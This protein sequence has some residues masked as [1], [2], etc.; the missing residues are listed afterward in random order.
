[1]DSSQRSAVTL[2]QSLCVTTSQT[3]E[4]RSR[5]LHGHLSCRCINDRV[6]CH[7]WREPCEVGSAAVG[8][9]VLSHATVQWFKEN[10]IGEC[11]QCLPGSTYCDRNTSL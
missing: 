1:M 2:C 10:L 8:M 11:G 9:D 5:G 6:C 4:C 7:T 3:S